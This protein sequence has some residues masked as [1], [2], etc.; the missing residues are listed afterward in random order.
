MFGTVWMKFLGCS[1]PGDTIT[2]EDGTEWEMEMK[3]GRDWGWVDVVKER[4]VIILQQ[5]MGTSVTGET[6]SKTG[7]DGYRIVYVDA[8]ITSESR[9]LQVASATD[10][11]PRFLRLTLSRRMLDA[12]WTD[13][14]MEG[15]WTWEWKS[16]KDGEEALFRLG[17]LTNE[18]T[19]GNGRYKRSIP[20]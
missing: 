12:G 6:D 20:W 14:W 5:S 17:Q 4:D 10:S 16:V 15:R 3:M 13:R 8:R 11:K 7:E 2:Y 18:T 9:R 19:V 1:V